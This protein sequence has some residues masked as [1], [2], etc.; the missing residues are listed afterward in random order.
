MDAQLGKNQIMIL[1]FKKSF[2]NR[3]KLITLLKIES[4]VF[5]IKSLCFKLKV[6]I[7][8]LQIFTA[9]NYIPQ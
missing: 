3:K 4:A 5:L 1:T 9:I 6:K 7:K 2:D 8:I